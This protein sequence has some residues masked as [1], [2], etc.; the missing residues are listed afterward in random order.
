MAKY[1]NRKTKIDG[2]TFDSAKESKRY[3]ELKILLRAGKIRDLILQPKFTLQEPFTYNGKVERAI[4]YTADFSYI[5]DG[6]K[7]VEDVKGFKTDIYKLKR[8]MFL[9]KYGENITFK[10]L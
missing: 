3:L 8:K 10:E 1:G 9:Y 7:I 5:K 6:E 2:F 4:T